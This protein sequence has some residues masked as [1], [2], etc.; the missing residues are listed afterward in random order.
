MFGVGVDIGAGYAVVIV[1]RFD[2]AVGI[3]IVGV[4]CYVVYCCCCCW[5]YYD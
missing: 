1:C 3:A 4:I 5:P 2:V